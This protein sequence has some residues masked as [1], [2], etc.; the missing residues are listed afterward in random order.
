M[1]V[2]DDPDA[3]YA[4]LVNDGQEYSLWPAATAPPPGWQ[5]VLTGSRTTCLE[6][7]DRAWPPGAL[8]RP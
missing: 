7:I 1:H 2:L 5:V 6:H 8:G 4:V 3:H